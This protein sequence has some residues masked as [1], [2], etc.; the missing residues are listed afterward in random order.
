VTGLDRLTDSEWAPKA[1]AAED[2]PWMKPI[3]P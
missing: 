3:L 2:V 1:K